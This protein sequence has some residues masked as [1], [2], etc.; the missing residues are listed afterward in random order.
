M[1]GEGN[2]QFEEMIAGDEAIEVGEIGGTCYNAPGD[3]HCQ[4]GLPNAKVT[5]RKREP[6][7]PEGITGV[8]Q[9]NPSK[10]GAVGE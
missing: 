3:A 9:A 10:V 2:L 1:V 6:I 4:K 7:F 8:K 5:R